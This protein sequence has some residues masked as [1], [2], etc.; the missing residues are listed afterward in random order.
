MM[1]HSGN[2]FFKRPQLLDY[3]YIHTYNKKNA[4]Q[5]RRNSYLEITEGTHNLSH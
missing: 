1:A 3:I 2:L 4:K 5:D